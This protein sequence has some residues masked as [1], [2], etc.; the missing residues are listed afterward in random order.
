MRRR[1]PV[2]S[3]VHILNLAGVNAWVFYKEFTK[4]NI[5]K[6]YFLFKLAEE[7]AEEYV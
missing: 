1:W 2:H 4:E 5:S 6:R 7:L 3:F